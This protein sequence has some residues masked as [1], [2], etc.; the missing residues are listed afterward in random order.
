MWA[1]L[2]CSAARPIYIGD[3][4]ELPKTGRDIMLAVDISGSMQEDDMQLNGQTVDRLTLV[5]S[6]LADFIS[7][8]E[9]DR[10]GL[11]LFADQAYIQAPLTFDLTTLKTLLD[12]SQIGFAGRKTAI[13]DAIGLAVKR[14]SDKDKQSEEE[15]NV[16]I[17]LTDGQNTA[18]AVEPIKASQIAAQEDIKIY[19]IGIGSDQAR[20]RPGMFNF[21]S[22]N[23][24]RDLD[25]KTLQSI[26]AATN[27]DFFRATSQRDLQG[28]YQHIDQLQSI[29]QDNQRFRPVTEYFYYPL[30]AMLALYFALGL[31]LSVNKLSPKEFIPH[32]KEK[33]SNDHW[34]ASND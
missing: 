18:G 31:I 20:A 11:I 9:G 12:E 4:V 28:I 19:T 34:E 26:A 15:Q 23:P 8:R 21:G 32:K 16:L 6:V 17:L 1:L 13:G 24:S 30:A 14:L 25:V 2:V 27:G 3:A 29:E 33:A 10:L 22:Y 5:K 7:Q